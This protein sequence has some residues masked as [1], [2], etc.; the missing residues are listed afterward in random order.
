MSWAE[1]EQASA[2]QFSFIRQPPGEGKGTKFKEAFIP[3]IPQ[4]PTLRWHSPESE[5]LL[6]C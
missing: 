6:K 2:L 3:S 4:E 5:G 1:F